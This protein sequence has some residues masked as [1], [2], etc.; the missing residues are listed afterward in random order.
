MM[1]IIS[2]VN[3]LPVVITSLILLEGQGASAQVIYGIPPA[4]SYTSPVAAAQPGQRDTTL[5]TLIVQD[6]TIAY[7]V[8]ALTQQTHLHLLYNGNDPLFLKRV[9]VHIVDANVMTAL[10]TVLQGTGL[11][12]RLAPDG[13]TVMIRDKSDM[14][15]TSRNRALS[16]IVAGRVTDSAS[17]QGIGGA[18]V[19]IDGIKRL[20]TVTSDSGRFTLR[21]VPTGDHILSV[22]IFG[23]KPAERTVV[24][25]DSARITVQII[26]VPVPTVLSGV[27]TTA[28]GLQRK[29]EVGNDITLLNV[30][31]IMQVA[32]ITSVTD[33]LETRVPGLTVVHSDGVP[34]D[35]ARL[36]LRGAGSVQLNNDPIIIVNGVR[37]YSNQSDPRNNNLARALSG[38]AGSASPQSGAGGRSSGYAAPS[39]LDQIDPSTIETIEVVKGPSAS[40]LYGSDAAS[41]VVVITTKQGQSGPT[42]WNLALGAGVNW[43]PGDWPA[44][45]YRFGTDLYSRFR[46]YGPFCSWT[47][48]YCA[49]DSVVPFQALNDPRY[50]VFSHGNDQTASLTISGGLPVLQYNLTGSAT[51]DVGNLKLPAIEQQRYDSLYGRIPG[52]LVRPDNY[53]TWGINGSLAAQPTPHVKVT[54][55]GSLFNS[56]QQRSSLEQAI[57][58]IDGEYIDDTAFFGPYGSRALSITPLITNDVERATAGSLTYTNALS[59]HWLARSWL[60]LDAVAGLNTIQRTDETYI[61]FGINVCG[62]NVDGGGI[63]G[64]TTGSYGIGRGTSRDA[65]LNAGTTVP[66][67]RQ[68]VTLAVGGNIYDESTG[69]V[70]AYTN[71]LAPGVSNPT[72]FPTSGCGNGACPSFFGQTTSSQRTYGWYVEPRF[73]VASRFFVAPGFRLDGGSGASTSSGNVDGL[74]AFPKVDFSYIAVDRQNERPLWGVLTLLRPR[75]AFGYAGTQPGPADKLRLFNVGGE[76]FTLTPPGEGSLTSGGACHP[77]VILDGSTEVPAVCLDALGNTQLRPERS[78]ELEGG[79]DATFWRGRL[80]L[81]YTQYNKTRKDAILSVPVA[82]SISGDIGE[83]F[84]IDKNIGEIRNTGTEITVNAT[85][86]QSRVLSWNV[87]ANLSNDNSLVVKLNPGQAP[88]CFGTG[89]P[90]QGTRIVAGYPLFGEWV[91]PIVSYVDVNHNG[92]IEPG[93]VHLGDSTVYV[94]QPVPKYQLNLTT[95]VA[96]LNGRLSLHATFAY[97]NRLTQDNQGAVGSG[98]FLLLPDAPHTPLGTQA[99]VQEVNCIGQAL[100]NGSFLGGCTNNGTLFGVIQTV[101]TFRFSD[102]SVNYDLPRTVSTWF[103]APRMTVAVQGSN[104]WLHTNY[105]GMDPDVNAFATVSA[106]DQTADL[107]QIPEPRTWWLRM[108]V[109]N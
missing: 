42:H 61:P 15:P 47:D 70:T 12:A 4:M 2:L 29:V 85:L 6:S 17:G 78:T 50:T 105:R 82:P 77:T 32:P 49:V 103:R 81:T 14:S 62:P 22:R 108:T 104:L 86:L 100:G 36:R 67:L 25:T 84:N 7:S 72:V 88:L 20:S 56:A 43:L 107:G 75:L 80:S 26:L 94:G 19:R 64:D 101:N 90:C 27:V 31:S 35:P 24:V 18:Q 69:D 73:N 58:Q 79:F 46:N 53:Q 13:E 76:G 102:L 33:L 9:T 41:G 95:D 34:G 60:P 44:P 5:V 57:S 11:V 59:L 106:G 38:G 54:L 55:Q 66:L 21:D 3:A 83:R 96:L 109:G 28:S 23:Y 45:Y 92:V 1:P 10:G 65:T 89:S 51:G 16:G 30:D 68:S 91:Q 39:P 37:V 48:P 99:A 8:R 63:C 97:Q 40:A 52:Y 98:A 74:S 71:Q 93:E 87:G